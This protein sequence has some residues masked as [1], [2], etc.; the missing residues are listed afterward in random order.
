MQVKVLKKHM[1]AGAESF[2]NP[3]TDNWCSNCAISKAVGN[4]ETNCLTIKMEGGVYWFADRR[5]GDFVILYDRLVWDLRAKLI[6][7]KEF[8]E[9]LP[10]SFTLIFNEKT[11]EV[12]YAS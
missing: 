7:K 10:D 11:K 3:Q 4:C 8:N 1:L 9:Q 5:I 12:N 6:S 2:L